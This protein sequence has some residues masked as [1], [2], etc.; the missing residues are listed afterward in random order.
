MESL[1]IH[2]IIFPLVLLVV[3][4]SY[5]GAN[6]ASTGTKGWF[7][8]FITIREF[9]IYYPL[10]LL[11]E[12]GV[13]VWFLRNIIKSSP[14]LQISILVLLALPFYL[15]TPFNDFLMRGSIPA[16]YVI[17]VYWTVYV[18]E[19]FHRQK[20][21]LVCILF[22]TSFSATH[23]Y[24]QAFCLLVKERKIYI[25]DPIVSFYAME[26][27]EYADMCDFQFFTHNY[28]ETFFFKYLAK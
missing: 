5:Y 6:S 22:L 24:T 18:I 2:N 19:N 26:D 1:S 15:I 9:C 3:V 23:T 25:K 8:E 17:C 16:L 14:I 27:K 10:F 12:I 21:L 11:I 13:Y 20:K 7:F 4:A 28:K